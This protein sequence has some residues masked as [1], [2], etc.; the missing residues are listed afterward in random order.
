MNRG[1]VSKRAVDRRRENGSSITVVLSASTT[2]SPNVTRENFLTSL[3]S[4]VRANLPF[5]R[6]FP[7]SFNPVKTTSARAKVT[8]PSGVLQS[9]ENTSGDTTLR[10]SVSFARK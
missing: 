6:E 4:R 2:S 1:G 9:L 8:A 10:I 7:S 5:S 3:A